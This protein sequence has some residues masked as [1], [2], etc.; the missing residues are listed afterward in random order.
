MFGIIDNIVVALAV[1]VGSGDA[2]RRPAI[3]FV[4]QFESA[5]GSYL[6]KASIAFGSLVEA[7]QFAQMKR[8]HGYNARISI[9]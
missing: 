2:G 7:E 4:V 3:D 1:A 8:Q 9:E 5:A 6:V